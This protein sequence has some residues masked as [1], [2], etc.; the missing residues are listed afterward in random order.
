[1]LCDKISAR[2]K[3]KVYKSIVGPV[4]I[5]GT[6]T[7]PIKMNKERKMFVVEMKMLQ[8]MCGVMK[9]DTI[10]NRRRGTVKVIQ[11]SKKIQERKLLGR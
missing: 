4:M 2:V 7:W 11:I 9:M 8:W 1:M 10:Q 3:G 5:N 6:E